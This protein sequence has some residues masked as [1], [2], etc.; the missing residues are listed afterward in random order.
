ME[1]ENGKK[2]KGKGI[3]EKGEGKREKRWSDGVLER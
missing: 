3:G 1:K 2:E